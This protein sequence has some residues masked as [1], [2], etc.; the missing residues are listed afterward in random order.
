MQRRREV[1]IGVY[2]T[3]NRDI[4]DLGLLAVNKLGSLAIE[5]LY[6]SR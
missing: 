2:L 1:E 3:A 6:A 4:G 5:E